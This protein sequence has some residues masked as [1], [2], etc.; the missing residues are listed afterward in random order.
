LLNSSAGRARRNEPA[1]VRML[2]GNHF[3][4]GTSPD[5]SWVVLSP[6]ERTALVVLSR[7]ML[8]YPY[9]VRYEYIEFAIFTLAARVQG[10][11]PLHAACVGRA[12][13]GILLVG[14]SGAGKSTVALH[15]LLQ[16]L[17]FVAEDAV[18]VVADTL[19]ATGIANYLHVSDDSLHWLERSRDRAMIR[20]SPV[21]RRRSG[22]Q[23]FEVD[24]R[25]PSYRLA[26]SPLK[27][28]AVVFLSSESAR[29]RSLLRALPRR[30][31]L[32]RLAS[33]QAYAANQPQWQAFERNLSRLR[34][35]ELRRGSHPREAVVALRETLAAARMSSTRRTVPC[36]SP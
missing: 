9:H 32:A 36:A 5:S 17:E 14:P 11:I 27:I 8:R 7:K 29:D 23:K 6:R 12:G 30:E 24:L 4:G 2:S 25:Q 19:Q 16:G 3:L 1:A 21:I 22:V 10:L 15:S 31:M 13:R 33:H 26:A 18:F 28:D 34:A 20:R 35:F